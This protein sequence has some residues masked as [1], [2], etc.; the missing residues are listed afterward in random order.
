MVSRRTPDAPRPRLTSFSAIISRTIGA[1]TMLADAGG[2]RQHQIA[3]QRFEIAVGDPHIGEL[4]E[5]GIDAVDRLALLHDRGDDRRALVDA[6][7]DFRRKRKAVRRARVSR[8]SDKR[9]RV[10]RECDRLS[11]IV[12]SIPAHAAD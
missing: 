3:L 11:V 6:R 10:A 9:Q 4:A 1:G 5:A 8:Q 2:M 7:E 12:R